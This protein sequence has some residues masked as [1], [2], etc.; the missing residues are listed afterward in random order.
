M[1]IPL[2]ANRMSRL[3]QR[4]LAEK[5]EIEARIE[6]NG[7]YQLSESFRDSLDELSMVDNHPGDLGTEMYERGKDNALLERDA[8]QLTRV[9]AALARMETGEYGRCKACG[10]FI[11][12]ER[13][14]AL[15]T[16]DYC[17]EHEPRQD[18]SDNRPAEE[19]FL[20]PPFGR[21]SLDEQDYT[22]FDGEDAWQSVAAVGTSSSPATA[23]DNE[24]HD[25]DSVYV[26]ADEN[27][28][29][30]EPIEN[31]LATD[32]TGKFVS[33]VRGRTY[34]HYMNAGE[35]EPLLEPDEEEYGS[36]Q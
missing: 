19:A 14:E 10:S 17:V 1:N 12:A 8:F 16:A 15:P 30:V 24:V 22:G 4:L 6:R 32:I 33:V 3:K 7:H 9:E 26:E 28:G 23:E 25:Y 20:R 35:G 36:L 31:F 29:Y 11:P 5:R 13:L 18:P 27:Q 34:R 2:D 21:T